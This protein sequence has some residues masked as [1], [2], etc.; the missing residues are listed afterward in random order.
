VRQQIEMGSSQNLPWE[1]VQVGHTECHNYLP[2]IVVND[3]VYPLALDKEFFAEFVRDFQNVS[4]DRQKSP[5]YVARSFLGSLARQPKWWPKLAVYGVRLLKPMLRDLLI[6]RGKVEKLTFFV[7]NFM[8]AQELQQ[9]RIDACSF[10]VM[11][12]EGP[13]SMCQHN[14]KRDDYILRPLDIQRADGS[15]L[16]YQP[17]KANKNLATIAI[18]TN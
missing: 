11:T 2:T 7:Q 16:N 18:H 4:W 10:M 6:A 17:L 14:A 1:A 9:D 8:D 3:T 13:V 12:D 15:T 5:W